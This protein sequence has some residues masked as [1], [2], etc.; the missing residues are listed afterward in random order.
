MGKLTQPA[1]VFLDYVNEDGVITKEGVGEFIGDK[2][3]WTVPSIPLNSSIYL[4]VR[5]LSPQFGTVIAERIPL[6]IDTSPKYNGQKEL[7][8]RTQ[9]GKN[10]PNPLY[11]KYLTDYTT[12]RFWYG[13]F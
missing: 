3:I 2:L 11:R 13:D 1:D 5:L 9:Y 8:G 4:Q 6:K 10:F 7:F 12:T